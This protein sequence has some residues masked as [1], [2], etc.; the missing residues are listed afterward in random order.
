MVRRISS[1]TIATLISLLL[2]TA[3][4]PLSAQERKASPNP[5]PKREQNKNKVV[6]P[7]EPIPT[8]YGMFV[9]VDLFGVGNKLFGGDMIS[10][11]VS[12]SVNLKNRFLPTVEAGY[13]VT[14][15]WS[16]DGEGINYKNSSPYFRIG[17]DY[18]FMAKKKNKN[19]IFYGGLRYGFSP[20]TFDVKSEPLTDPIYGGELSNPD[21]TDPI[22]G[23]SV[24]YNYTGQKTTMQWMELVLGVKAQIA[25][26]F[27]M[28][29]SVR[30]KYK[31]NSS[32]SKYGNPWTVPGYGKY[33][34]NN[35]G[36]TY[37]LIYRIPS[38]KQKP[39]TTKH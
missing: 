21:L 25:G 7:E 38:K 39:S 3:A 37:N 11:D 10:S 35:L 13:G 23:G 36:L 19:N 32:S 5:T 18:N 27:Y 20:M 12:V 2:W 14:D 34:N 30:M 15:A 31:M 4:V 16:D 6:E 29:W 1:Y 8:F 26:N 9:G 33:G 28:G 24:P 17:M 22:W